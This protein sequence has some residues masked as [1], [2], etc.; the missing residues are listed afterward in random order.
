[1]N[2]KMKMDFSSNLMRKN[3]MKSTMILVTGCGGFI[4]ANLLR[5]LQNREYNVL[6]LDLYHTELDL[7]EMV[8]SC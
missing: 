6:S 7:D 3:D 4:G 1:M 5:D 2:K 8:L